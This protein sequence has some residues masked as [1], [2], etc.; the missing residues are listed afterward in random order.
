VAAAVPAETA[1][2]STASELG[3]ELALVSRMH[4]AWRAGD[5][6]AVQAA[7][8]AH[9]RQF[10]AGSLVE[11]REAVKVMLLCR[12]VSAER[13]GQLALQFVRQHPGSPYA[14]RVRA[15]CNQLRSSE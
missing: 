13:A 11:E 8:S 4:A 3:G 6:P 10:P 5:F 7:I 15:A 12:S 2:N 9:E 14:A 1:S